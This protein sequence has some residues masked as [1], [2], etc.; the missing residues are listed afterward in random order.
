MLLAVPGTGSAIDRSSGAQQQAPSAA[1]NNTTTQHV[2]PDS[3]S[4]PGDTE[5]LS[6]W[7]ERRLLARLQQSTLAIGQRDYARARDLLGP[8]YESRLGQYVEI[9]GETDRS[10]STGEFRS[11]RQ[12]QSAFTNTSQAYQRTYDEYE[13]ARAQGNTTA[14]IRRARALN[15]LAAN[16]TRLNRSLSRGYGQL[17]NLTGIDTATIQQQLRNTTDNISSQQ[18]TVRS[19]TLTDTRL[20]VT[21]NQT[22]VAFD[23]P[24]LI[25]GTV[26]TANGTVVTNQSGVVAIGARVYPVRTDENGQFTASYRPIS[27]SANATAVDVQYIPSLSSPYLGVSTSTPVA[28]E[29]VTPS[30]SATV[31]PT[32]AGYGDTVA[33]RTT[34]TVD[35]RTVPSVPVTVTL[36][37]NRRSQFTNETGIAEI[38]QQLPASILAGSQELQ[39]A[40]ARSELAVG[41]AETTTPLTVVSK[42]TNMTI[43]ATETDAGTRIQ[44]RLLTGD[45]VGISARPLTVTIG[46]T[47]QTVTTNQ[48]GYYQLTVSNVSTADGN[49]STVPV[50]VQFDGRGT[51]LRNSSATATVNLTSTTSVDGGPTESFFGL[52]TETL[53]GQLLGASVVGMALIAGMIG[54]LRRYQSDDMAETD[55]TTTVMNTTTTSATEPEE[56]LERAQNALSNGNLNRAT[57]AA[58]ASVRN[59]YERQVGIGGSLTQREFL[60]VCRTQLPETD[61]RRLEDI[62]DAYERLLFSGQSD[63]ELASDAV[64]AASTLLADQTDHS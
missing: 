53:P 48:S 49:P 31:T 38:T 45:E 62:S 57:V 59:H 43:S 7:L 16:A 5:Q 6:Q 34:M 27:L 39:I 8:E 56:Y 41:P 1:T 28:V 9:A 12:N 52:L 46:E 55:R 44:G 3:V 36:A 42:A 14:A 19:Q 63:M 18:A 22:T 25:S 11:I 35:G 20:N 64:S 50:T 26:E 61:K 2:D 4:E 17:G 13:Q 10:E 23:D 51:N 15:S 33:L 32:T 54:F 37:G 47:T 21:T 60:D 24:I 29:Q 58:Y 40:H 30:L